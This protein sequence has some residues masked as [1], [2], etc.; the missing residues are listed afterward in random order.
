MSAGRGLV[1]VLLALPRLAHA[2]GGPPDT[3]AWHAELG[4]SGD[5]TN[6]VFYQGAFVDTAFL[7]RQ[8]VSDPETRA[9]VVGMASLSGTCAGRSGSYLLQGNGQYG[10]KVKEGGWLATWRQGFTP[11]WRLGLDQRFD[12]RDDRSFGRLTRE[13]LANGNAQITRRWGGGAQVTLGN[14]ASFENVLFDTTAFLLTNAYDRVALTLEGAD[15]LRND[16]TLTSQL[17][18]RVFRDSTTRDQAELGGTARWRRY[19]GARGDAELQLGA[20]RRWPRHDVPSTRD[21]FLLTSVSLENRWRLGP[22]WTSIVQLSLDDTRYHDPDEIFFDYA[23]ARAALG[24]RAEPDWRFSLTAAPRIE[25]LIAPRAP[26]EEYEEVGAGLDASWIRPGAYLSLLPAVGY[27]DYSG[28]T[29]IDAFALQHSSYV[30]YEASGYV[31]QALPGGLRV[32]GAGSARW[33]RHTNSDDDLTSLY[34]SL[35]LRRIF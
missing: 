20:T 9:A 4:G 12:Y 25:W 14:F 35:D 31:D 21:R 13:W 10:N 28:T 22:R 23:I 30:F 17:G 16:W 24:I 5:G 18:T 6:E 1:L 32:R 33:E 2:D 15:P 27:R 34:F 7:P 3:S 11:A 8:V 19:F 29:T 26:T